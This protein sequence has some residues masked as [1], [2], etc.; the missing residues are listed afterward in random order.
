MMIFYHFFFY[1]LQYFYKDT[2]LPFGYQVVQGK[3]K[4]LIFSLYLTVFK[5]RNS[6]YHL[7]KGTPRPLF[8]STIM[9]SKT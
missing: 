6:P 5:I 4:C 9:N 1:Q 7:W 3:T 2:I 8:L